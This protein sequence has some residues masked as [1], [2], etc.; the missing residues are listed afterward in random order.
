MSFIYKLYK[1]MLICVAHLNTIII[2]I[3]ICIYKK[4]LSYNF[5]II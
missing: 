1:Y 5:E 3:I 4:I 2:I